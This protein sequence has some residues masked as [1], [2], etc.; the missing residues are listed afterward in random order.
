[1]NANKRTHREILIDIATRAMTERG[2]LP[3]FSPDVMAEISRLQEPPIDLAS[4]QDLRS[5]MWCSIDNDDSRDLDQLS[6]AQG[7]PGGQVKILV[8]IADV[9]ALVK[10][11]MAINAHAEHNTTSVYTPA[12]IFPMLP[13]QL[14]TGLTSLNAG[15][16]RT[17]IIVEMVID[18]DG[19]LSASNIY[20]AVVHNKAKLA[21][22]SVAAWLDGNGPAPDELASVPGLEDNLRLQEQTAQV[23]GKFRYIHGALS[24]ETR[25]ANPVMD[26]DQMRSMEV[27][28]KNRASE[29]IENFMVAANG[30]T[31]RFLAAHHFASI[32]RVVEAPERWDRIVQLAQQHGTK[33]PDAP[34][35]IALEQFLQ[36]EK[37]A[38]P[39]YFPD[40][41]LAIIKLIGPGEYAAEPPGDQ[42]P[43]HF[44]LAARDYAHSTAPNRRYPDLITQRLLKAALAGQSAPY[45][46]NELQEIAKHCT[47]EEDEATKVERQVNKSAAALLLQSHIG[48]RFD[49]IV[50]GASMKGTW[51]RLLQIPVEG[52]LVRG[53]KGVDVGDRLHVQLISVDVEQGFID[54][55]RI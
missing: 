40:L 4:L 46:L 24:L 50:T 15:A 36:K 20:R 8:G 41:S 55:K 23:M 33:L 12:I 47:I 17:A 26:G 18:P 30:V 5:L 45:T 54:F 10:E 21:Y 11:G 37:S 9:S 51:V 52:K 2:L 42:V 31:A 49:A 14:S 35:S 38:D 6:V 28:Q 7:M 22:N 48:E 16:D 29:I 27:E 44:G 19:S 34:N 39:Q 32:R 13:E 53:F 1:M 25:D 43:D 3:N